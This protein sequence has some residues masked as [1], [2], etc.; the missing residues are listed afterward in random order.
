[1]LEIRQRYVLNDAGKPIAVQ[2]PIAQFETLLQMVNDPEQVSV[3]MEDG[4]WTIEELKE[5]VAIGLKA[6]EEGRYTDY[7]EA[8][9]ES[10]FE[11]IKRK[12]RLQ[13]GIEA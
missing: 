12:G 6:L 9:L 7:D 8:G 1:M 4:D 5:E 13:R 10:F 3:V 2:I 11:G